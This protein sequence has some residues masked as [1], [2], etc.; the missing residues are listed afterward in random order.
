MSIKPVAYLVNGV[1]FSNKINADFYANVLNCN[2]KIIG[3]N[4][5]KIPLYT[6]DQLHLDTNKH[7]TNNYLNY[8]EIL[9]DMLDS[10]VKEN[11]SEVATKINTPNMELVL[12]LRIFSKGDK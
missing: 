4:F 3:N 2:E 8:H 5:V 9:E 6:S 11:I 10:I 7:E 1:A 12:N